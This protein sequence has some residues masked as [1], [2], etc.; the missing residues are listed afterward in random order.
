V[1]T[2]AFALGVVC[3]LAEPFCA[4]SIP[5]YQPVRAYR[6]DRLDG[7]SLGYAMAQTSMVSLPGAF[8]GLATWDC[9][10]LTGYPSDV[11][12]DDKGMDP[13]VLSRP[14]Q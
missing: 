6:V 5:G 9:S 7:F 2:L 11:R 1:R 12:D 8:D 3:G 10:K 13:A 4:Q 14:R